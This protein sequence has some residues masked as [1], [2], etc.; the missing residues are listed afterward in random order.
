MILAP[1]RPTK[2]NHS[3]QQGMTFA[4]P[5]TSDLI[6]NFVSRVAP[7]LAKHCKRILID[8]R[9]AK[10]DEFIEPKFSRPLQSNLQV[11]ADGRISCGANGGLN[12]S[13]QIGGPARSNSRLSC[14]SE[15]GTILTRSRIMSVNWSKDIDQTL[16]AAKEQSCPILLDFSAAPA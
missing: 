5:K 4:V 9:V 7:I 13:Y 6:C 12:P 15:C 16:A 1:K 3:Q 14:S 2:G 10:L 8:T 11:S